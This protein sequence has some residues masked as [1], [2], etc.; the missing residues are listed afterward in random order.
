MPKKELDLK[1]ILDSI[2]SYNSLL[3]ELDDKKSNAFQALTVLVQVAETLISELERQRKDKQ[4]CIEGIQQLMSNML[5][6]RDS[7]PKYSDDWNDCNHR[8]Q[9][10][11]NAFVRVKNML[12]WENSGMSYKHF[13]KE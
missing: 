9:A 6:A 3:L 12:D 1:P 4:E 5:I 10:Y 2:K 7:W 11:Q 8:Y 13:I